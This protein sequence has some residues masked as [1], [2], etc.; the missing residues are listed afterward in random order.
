MFYVYNTFMDYKNRPKIGLALGSGGAKGLAHIGV[1]KILEHYN[2]PIDF[3]AG[4]SVGALMGAHYAVF[5]DTRKLEDFF[6]S[7]TMKQ[8]FQLFDPT[9]QGGLL[10]GKKLETYISEFLEGAHFHSVQIPFAAVATDFITAQTVVFTE[11]NL[12]KAVRASTSI[13]AIF[14]PLQYKERLLADGGLSN[15]VPVDVVRSMGADIVIAV[16]LDNVYV[17][18]GVTPALTRTPMQSIN[19]LR[20]NIA[21]QSTKT[22]DIIIS[23]RD[24]YNI[25]LIGWNYFFDAKKTK[26]V[27]HEGEKATEALIPEIQ[28]LLHKKSQKKTS[29]L[30]KFFTLLRRI[31]R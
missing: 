17:Q 12:S 26:D 27:I 3:I 20:H 28:N 1:L 13:P 11:G 9:F 24:I 25:G 18:K 31:T 19:V 5:K 22:A 4:S 8:G 6:I 21:L 14:Q 7:F 16:N 15:S 29:K 30:T 2:I 23:P 10:K